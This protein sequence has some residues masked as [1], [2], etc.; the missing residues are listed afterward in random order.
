MT[1]SIYLEI[2]PPTGTTRTYGCVL[3]GET[4]KDG[5]RKFSDTSDTMTP[6]AFRLSVKPPEWSGTYVW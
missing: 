4:N 2:G 6:P 1:V 5:R 3:E